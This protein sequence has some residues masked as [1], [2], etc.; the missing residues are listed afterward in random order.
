MKLSQSGL[1]FPL[2]RAP[3]TAFR[4]GPGTA[5]NFLGIR[6]LSSFASFRTRM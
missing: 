1:P 5:L 2:K 4:F 6:G 3:V